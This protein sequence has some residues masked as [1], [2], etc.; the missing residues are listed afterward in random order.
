MNGLS[1]HQLSTG[2]GSKTI[3]SGLDLPCLPRGKISVLLGPNGCGKSTLLRALAGLNPAQGKVL[4]DGENLASMTFAARARQIVYLP[5]S[6]PQGVHLHVLESVIVAQRASG[7]AENPA[8]IMDIL[9]R[10]GI[11]HLAMHYLDRLS[12]GQKQ[13]VGL[14]QSLVRKP[15]LLLLDE[16]LSA[17]DLN[18]QFHVMEQVARETRARQLVTVIVVH[19]MNIA[20]RHGDHIV[21][22]KDGQLIASGE[23]ESVITPQTLQ[24]VYNVE[25]RIERCSRGRPFVVLDGVMPL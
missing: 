8:E 3:I 22:L 2:Y 7:E 18:Y 5:Q 23:P 16:P 1:L 19:D 24:K 4:L 25:G 10:L 13:L 12:G 21:M 17:L 9:Q 20:L 11:A 14:A 15:R 6:L